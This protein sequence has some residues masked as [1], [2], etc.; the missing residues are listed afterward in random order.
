VWYILKR[1]PPQHSHRRRCTFFCDHYNSL[2]SGGGYA[3]QLDHGLVVA[4]SNSAN[5]EADY[6][7]ECLIKKRNHKLK[8]MSCK[9][10]QAWSWNIQTL[11][12]LVY[13]PPN[14]KQL[15][16]YHTMP[17]R[18][19]CVQRN[20]T[21]MLLDYCTGGGA[22][23]AA[24]KEGIRFSLVRYNSGMQHQHRQQQ[25]Q[26][27]TVEDQTL[28][29]VLEEIPPP[30]ATTTATATAATHIANTKDLAHSHASVPSKPKLGLLQP[31]KNRPNHNNKSN[32]N[33]SNKRHAKPKRQ[34]GQP[35]N[36]I[37]TLAPLTL[38]SHAAE[39]HPMA[40]A[41]A[42]K[43]HDDNSNN[44][45]TLNLRM[46]QPHPYIAAAKNGMYTDPQTGLQYPTDLCNY[47]GETKKESGRHSLMGVG[48][49]T[50]TVFHIKVCFCHVSHA[51]LVTNAYFI[52]HSYCI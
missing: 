23:N 52:M 18:T 9:A 22:A 31:S 34:T 47:L 15:N 26:Q 27:Q 45:A 51:S 42:K 48:Q 7:G 2:E 32:S 35:R 6:G 17:E 20:G 24:G 11:G 4:N 46:L 33:K 19:M 1:R 13:Q 49:Y 21:T 50:K 3:L 40:T 38:E 29:G 12:V 14:Q 30:T 44:I 16:R 10:R 36:Q 8:I 5:A 37:H 39:P 43:S 28:P 25:L 41:V